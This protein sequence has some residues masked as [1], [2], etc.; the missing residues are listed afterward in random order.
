MN[1]I[2]QPLLNQLQKKL[3]IDFT[4]QT[5]QQWVQYISDARS[6]NDPLTEPNLKRLWLTEQVYQQELK[7]RQLFHL[8]ITYKPYEDRTYTENIINTF[9]TNFYM[10]RFLPQLMGTKN[11]NRAVHRDLLPITYCFIDEHEQKAVER[12]F[13]GYDFPQKFHHH[14]I[15]SLHQENAGA[16][17]HLMGN[18]TFARYDLSPKIM[19][20]N[21]KACGAQRMLYAA[22][23]WHKYPDFLVFPD[24][25]ALRNELLEV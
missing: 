1:T 22:K 18:N 11:Y 14:A 25:E 17:F 5:R 10:T 2:N 13:G 6:N 4:H 23:M 24:G 7:G 21:L 12:K 20:S 19:T 16:L 15:L 8:T 3:Q 9:F